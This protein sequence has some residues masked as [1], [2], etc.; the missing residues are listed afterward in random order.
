MS[1]EADA[2]LYATSPMPTEI[3]AS[4][5][6]AAGFIA[7]VLS[8]T[9]TCPL[10]VVKMIL[11]THEGDKTAKEIVK[12][13]LDKDGIAG[14][15]RGNVVACVNSGPMVAIKY[16]VIDELTAIIGKGQPID[17]PTRCVIGGIAGIISQTVVFPLDLVLTRLTVS[18]HIYKNFFQSVGQIVKDDGILGLWQ[19]LAPTITGA[20]VYEGSQYF[21]SGGFK[22]FYSQKEGRVAAWRNLL[23]GACAGAIS[24]T[25][26][27]PFDVMR[28]RLMCVDQQGNK[29]YSSWPACFKSI[30]KD[31][32]PFGFFKGAH[33]NL[34]KVIP[35]A[36]IQYTLNEEIKNFFHNYNLMARIHLKRK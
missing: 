31:E 32:G 25:I 29:R 13:I 28:R 7:G 23:I 10:D 19:G 20:I 6:L 35:Y 8:R 30:V 14:F 12:S 11:Q 24:Q 18:P 33:V 27:F 17:G 21:V 36:A 5:S 1:K 26:A 22:Q 15:W 2:V 3:S 4:Q 34:V 16:L 9:I